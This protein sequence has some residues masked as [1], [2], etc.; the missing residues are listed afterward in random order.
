MALIKSIKQA[1][2][3]IGKTLYWDD[4]NT[5][6]SPLS[7]TLTAITRR[8]IC[9]DESEDYMPLNHFYRLRTTKEL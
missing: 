1:E 4:S 3:N 2:D 9:F 7:G 8:Q 6:F 5:I